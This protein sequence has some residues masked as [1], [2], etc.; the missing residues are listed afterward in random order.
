[1]EL[2]SFESVDGVL[3]RSYNFCFSNSPIVY[4]TVEKQN[5]FVP[6]SN[7]TFEE[8]ALKTSIL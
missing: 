1:M 4:S 3:A 5:D 8:I 7:F 6:S 2:P